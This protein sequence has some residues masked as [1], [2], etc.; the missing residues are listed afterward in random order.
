MK[1]EDKKYRRGLSPIFR[2]GNWHVRNLINAA[3]NPI[4]SLLIDKYFYDYTQWSNTIPFVF[5]IYF[6]DLLGGESIIGH[7][8]YT[9]RNIRMCDGK[10]YTKEEINYYSTMN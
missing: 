9:K 1:T 3:E 2:Q 7:I 6:D 8:N 10:L 5:R 4:L